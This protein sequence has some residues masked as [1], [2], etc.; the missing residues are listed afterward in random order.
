MEEKNQNISILES[1]KIAKQKSYLLASSTLKERNLFLSK[2]L[3]LLGNKSDF[4]ISENKKDLQKAKADNLLTSVVKRLEL[5]ESKIKTMMD[6]IRQLI[7]LDD[8]LGVVQLDR[9]LDEDL[10]LTRISVPV[11]LIG[12]IF[13]SRPDA[14]IQ[15]ATLA[16]KSGNCAILKGGKEATHSNLALF[17][18]IKE[19]AIECDKELGK[20]I[21]KETIVLA[22]NREQINSLLALDDVI[23]LMI[24]RGSNELVKY[25]KEHTKI[26][27]LGH[28]DGICHFYIDKEVNIDEAV[29][30][31]L[32]AKTQYPAVCNAIETILVHKE[33][34]AVF[35][36]KLKKAFCEDNPNCFVEIRGDKECCLIIDVNKASEEDWHTE[37][38][39][40]IVS[41]KVVSSIT[42]AVNHINHYG[43]HHSDGI[44]ST[45]AESCNYFMENVDSST[46]MCNASTRFADGFRYGF[47]A[48]VG[49]STSKIHARGPV[50]LEGLTIYKYQLV[51]NGNIV[52]DY[53]TGRKKFLH[54]DI[55]RP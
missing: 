22:Q 26:P 7:L 46:V 35:L 34:A 50:G 3:T 44:A 20:D 39:D 11:G 10:R 5:N 9:L 8:P 13:E 23:D 48:E 41:I 54:K 36:P 29:K 24:P 19:T 43:S 51:G 52:S 17:S 18:L 40:L 30:L 47:G 32:D 6:G 28:A 31:C 14:F 1:A 27:V 16:I 25:I 37:Y 15:I 53:V 12:V 33:V 21:F 38:G 49:I 4:L 42:E 55:D 2:L 45:N